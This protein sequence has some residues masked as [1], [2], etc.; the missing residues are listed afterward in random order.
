[1]TRRCLQ[2][3]L[4]FCLSL[5]TVYSRGLRQIIAAA[6]NWLKGVFIMSKFKDLWQITV[7][8]L[9]LLVFAV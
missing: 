4:S 8:T 7:F 1:M 6:E 5:H 9:S 2:L 3:V